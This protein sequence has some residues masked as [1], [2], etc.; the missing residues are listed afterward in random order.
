MLETLGEGAF[1]LVKKAIII[2][3]GEKHQVAIKMLKSEE[4]NLFHRLG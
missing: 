1:G 2:K 3:D 4:K